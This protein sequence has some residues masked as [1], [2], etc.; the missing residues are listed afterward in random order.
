[1]CI[2]LLHQTTLL[3]FLPLQNGI[4]MEDALYRRRPRAPCPPQ[5]ANDPPIRTPCAMEV[6][7][8]KDI[9][10]KGAF[11]LVYLAEDRVRGSRHAIKTISKQCSPVEHELVLNEQ[12]LMR[13]LGDNP[14]FV[15]LDASWH[16]NQCY[17]LAM[18]S[19]TSST[20]AE[21]KL[22]PAFSRSYLAEISTE[23]YDAVDAWH[24]TALSSTRQ[25][26]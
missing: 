9:L 7:M 12:R 23:K 2:I 1:M 3:T 13:E 21:P 18:V 26:W 11:G 4:V 22:I 6:F 19:L 15:N 20:H 5:A 8:V 10:G 16:D 24:L 25:N 17:Y 14:W